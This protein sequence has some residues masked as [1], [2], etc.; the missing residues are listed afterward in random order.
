MTPDLQCLM[1]RV[2][3]NREHAHE[4]QNFLL[5]AREE[6]FELLAES[7]VDLDRPLLHNVLVSRVQALASR[8][9]QAIGSIEPVCDALD[10]V[11]FAESD[12]DPQ[13]MDVS[14][15][16]ANGRTEGQ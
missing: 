7:E 8:V 15:W 1:R 14:S 16:P 11:A 9:S 5:E 2:S 12:D 4:V 10:Q 6:L 13:A 3:R